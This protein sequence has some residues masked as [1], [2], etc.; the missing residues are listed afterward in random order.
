MPGCT[1]NAAKRPLRAKEF[2]LPAGRFCVILL[3]AAVLTGGFRVHLLGFGKQDPA[4]LASLKMK[5]SLSGFIYKAPWNKEDRLVLVN[6][7]FKALLDTSELDAET[8]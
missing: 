4:L 2:R 3:L 1:V 7:A 8:A 6:S 5:K